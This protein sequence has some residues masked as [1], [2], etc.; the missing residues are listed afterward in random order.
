[1]ERTELVALLRATGE[2][3]LDDQGR[4]L[5]YVSQPARFRLERPSL[6]MGG[7]LVVTRKEETGEYVGTIFDALPHPKTGRSYPA[8]HSEELWHTL[9]LEEAARL[10]ELELSSPVKGAGQ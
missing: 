3:I 5:G 2:E 4:M 8:G 9:S 6:A 10:V 1:M 7:F